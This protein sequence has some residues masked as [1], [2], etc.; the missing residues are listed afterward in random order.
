MPGRAQSTHKV[1]VG[2]QAIFRRPVVWIVYIFNEVNPEFSPGGVRLYYC[3]LPSATLPRIAADRI[4]FPWRIE[5]SP[6]ILDKCFVFIF[7]GLAELLGKTCFAVERWGG[8]EGRR[9]VGVEGRGGHVQDARERQGALEREKKKEEKHKLEKIILL[10]QGALVQGLRGHRQVHSPVLL[11]LFFWRESKGTE[12]TK[13][14]IEE[15]M[16][17]TSLIIEKKLLSN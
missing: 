3:N 14:E 7:Q 10:K 16:M 12:K 2:Q 17:R 6:L 9:G 4:R 5:A 1:Q 13:K 11:F 15:A 8:L